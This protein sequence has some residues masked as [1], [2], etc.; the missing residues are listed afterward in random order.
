MCIRDRL[1]NTA[2]RAV[3]RGNK[4][5]KQLIIPK[6]DSRKLNA[7]MEEAKKLSKMEIIENDEK[8]YD[9]LRRLIIDINAIVDQL[10]EIYS[11]TE[12]L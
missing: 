7:K 8:K 5:Q 10:R 12:G 3:Y 9:E 6:M 2:E 1:V 4:V 11:V